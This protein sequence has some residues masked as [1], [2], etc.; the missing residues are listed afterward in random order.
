MGHGFGLNGNWTHLDARDLTLDMSLPNRPRNT[1]NLSLDWSD[2]PRGLKAGL[3]FEYR[4]S[5][6][7]DD[8][9]IQ[10]KAGDFSL[11][12]L[13]VGK[14]IGTDV[15]LTF[16]VENLADRQLDQ[17]SDLFNYY[18]RGRFFTLGALY[19]IR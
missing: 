13:M 19:R 16:G 2:A 7:L 1:V 18:E 8:D 9:G 17:V 11:L 3:R 4:S 6:W 12:H 5:Q 15:E 10:Y 14:E